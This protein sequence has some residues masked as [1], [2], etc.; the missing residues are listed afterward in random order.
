[1][2]SL[3]GGSLNMFGSLGQNSYMTASIIKTL[4]QVFDNVDIY[5]NFDPVG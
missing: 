5:P 1:L 2:T 4:Q 3:T